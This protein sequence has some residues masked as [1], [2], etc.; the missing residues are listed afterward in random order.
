MTIVV[1]DPQSTFIHIPKTAGVAMSQWLINNVSGSY[2][3]QK[4]HGGK[5]AAQKRIRKHYAQQTNADKPI[6][7]GFT[8]CCVRNPW[9]RV[10][11]AY[12]YYVKRGKIDPYKFTW[13]QF[14]N[15]EWEHGKWGCVHKQQVTYFDDVDLIIRYENLEKDF[16]KVQEFYGCWKPL[17]KANASSHKDYKKYYSNPKWIDDVEEHYKDDI[18]R[19][20][21]SFE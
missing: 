20:S 9:E 7:F 1:K 6:D 13:E 12:H 17:F 5:H 15:R 10:V 2:L 18:A 16:M 14:I 4:Q 19:F 8:F 21:F 11:S 3:L